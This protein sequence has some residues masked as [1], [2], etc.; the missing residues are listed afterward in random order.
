MSIDLSSSDLISDRSMS[1][2]KVNSGLRL[3]FFFLFPSSSKRDS[4]LIL[5]SASLSSESMSC[6]F[7]HF[8]CGLLVLGRLRFFALNGVDAFVSFLHSSLKNVLIV[9]FGDSVV[10]FELFLLLFFFWVFFVLLAS[11]SVG[12]LMLLSSMLLV[13]V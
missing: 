8:G 13:Y 3:I 4:S 12:M 2:S 9:V 1:L 11:I 7:L 6:L 5:E 10:S